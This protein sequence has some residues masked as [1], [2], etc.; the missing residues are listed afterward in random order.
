MLWNRMN[1]ADKALIISFLSFL[2]ALSLSLFWPCFWTR[3]LLAATEAATVGGIADWF[4]VTALFEKPL[5]FSYHT[6]ILPRRRRSFIEASVTLVQTEFLSKRKLLALLQHVR[7][8][9]LLLTWLERPAVKASVVRGILRYAR[10]FL[11][12][13]DKETAAAELAAAWR[14]DVLAKEGKEI[15]SACAKWLQKDDRDAAI[16]T[17]AV[18]YLRKKA[19]DEAFPQ[20][21]EA[22]LDAYAKAHVTNRWS[23]LLLGI[24]HA[25]DVVN[26]GD[27]ALGV[28]RETMAALDDMA[29][30]GSEKQRTFLSLFWQKAETLA[31]D[32]AT[33][34][35]LEEF[36]ANLFD[37]VPLEETTERI[38]TTLER[39]LLREHVPEQLAAVPM[40][41]EGLAAV[42]SDEVERFLAGLKNDVKLQKEIDGFLYDMAARSLLAAQ[43][44]VGTVVRDVLEKMTDE[45]L[46]R[47]VYDKVETDLLWIRMNG[48]LVG[49]GLGILLFVLLEAIG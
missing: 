6:A 7:L 48:C 19:A 14:R 31:E 29:I 38:L 16:L 43:E 26:F 13:L 36:V 15:F 42:L 32:P 40:L 45:E 10:D 1:R 3:L 46:N 41:R 4:A 24:G 27:M 5:G 2:A 39:N 8:L 18:L 34:K 25:T 20:R 12:Q 44:M 35:L 17:E 28:Q 11:R 30:R 49:G 37:A 9:D 23:L 21:L 22:F 33:K 47:L